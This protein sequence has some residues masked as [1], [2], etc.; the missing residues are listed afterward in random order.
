MD[1]RTGNGMGTERSTTFPEWYRGREVADQI[2]LHRTAGSGPV[3]MVEIEP[4]Q[5]QI[6]MP[7]LSCLV[8]I[9]NGQGCRVK[10]H[11]GAGSFKAWGPP[12]S[13]LTTMPDHS[14]S[15]QFETAHAVRSF[16]LPR[17]VVQD[18]IEP[19]GMAVPEFG[20]LHEGPV[21]DPLLSSLFDALW[22]AAGE[23]DG[24]VNRLFVDTAAASLVLN[25]LQLSGRATET[26]RGGLSGNRLR[27]VTE[28]MRTNL[29]GSIS[30]AD[31]A[32]LAEL[33]PHHFAR[34][35]KR[36]TGLPPHRYQIMLRIERAKEM[37]VSTNS[38][39]IE[40]GAAIGWQ[41]PAYFARIFAREVGMPPSHYRR[42]KC[43]SRG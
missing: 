5:G 32:R 8:M 20:K 2:K 10:G 11:L 16:G 19:I 42:K 29:S 36:S 35:F 37:L 28:Y 7:A 3:H 33:S 22:M 14:T 24:N 4:A 9:E 15:L 17:P 41:D 26:V 18:I 1:A 40:I 13:L 27:A 25:M 30:L 12:G 34:A 38:S 23:H 43:Q 39:I 21:V 31:L 6:D